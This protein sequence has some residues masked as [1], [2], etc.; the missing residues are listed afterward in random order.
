LGRIPAYSFWESPILAYYLDMDSENARFLKQGVVERCRKM[1]HAQRVRAYIGHSQAIRQIHAAGERQRGVRLGGNPPITGKMD[2]GSAPHLL[3]GIGR[4]LDD[5]HIGWA[6]ISALALAFNGLIQAS[7]VEA[8]LISLEDADLNPESLAETL[9]AQ[10]LS[11]EVRMGEEGDPLGF[12]VRIS[13]GRSNQVDLIGGIT[14]LDPGFFQ[15]STEDEFDGLRFRMS[16]P[17]DLIALKVYAGGPKD[18]EDAKGVI[19]VQQAGID[20]DLLLDLCK[21]FGPN[22]AIVC[23]KLLET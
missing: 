11:V 3:D 1:T 2:Y 20:K 23:S 9:R 13:D 5:I 18:L 7:L 17:E 21:R 22:E 15:R 16:S 14:R 19:E 10:G 4:I 6:S 12:V 8:A